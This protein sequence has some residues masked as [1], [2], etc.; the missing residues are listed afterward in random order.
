MKNVSLC[1]ILLIACIKQVSFNKILNVN[2][3]IIEK[4]N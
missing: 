3:K 2:L 4:W 1:P